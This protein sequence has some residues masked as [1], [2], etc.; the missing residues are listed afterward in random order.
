L[1]GRLATALAVL[2]CSVGF[3]GCMYPETQLQ[4]SAPPDNRV[5][6]GWQDRVFLSAREIVD[7]MC[8]DGRYFLQCDHAG[9]ITYSCTCAPR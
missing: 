8:A 2:G 4:R 9:S 7:Y 5:K 3:G 6:L 1:R